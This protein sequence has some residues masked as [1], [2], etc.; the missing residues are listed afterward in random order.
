[1]ST[2]FIHCSPMSFVDDDIAK[3]EIA[4]DNATDRIR[5]GKHF[6]FAQFAR[7]ITILRELLVKEYGTLQSVITALIDL[8]EENKLRP[9]ALLL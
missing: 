9:A 5:Y 6:K 1:M 7:H 2:D 3:I 8:D 4:I